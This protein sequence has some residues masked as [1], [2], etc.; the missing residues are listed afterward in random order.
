[1]HTAR[2]EEISEFADRQKSF[3]GDSEKRGQR[4]E[5]L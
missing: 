3:L 1:M 5:N 2:D 4:E